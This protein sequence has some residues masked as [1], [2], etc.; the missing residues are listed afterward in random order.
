MEQKF[1]NFNKS[2]CIF[3]TN[4]DIYVTFSAS[5]CWDLFDQINYRI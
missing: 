3:K 4:K 5:E 2:V 1:S